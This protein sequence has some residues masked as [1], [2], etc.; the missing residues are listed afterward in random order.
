MNVFPNKIM[1]LDEKNFFNN[2]NNLYPS[3]QKPSSHHAYTKL[4]TNNI[5]KKLF[6][7]KN[8]TISS[9]R[10]KYK[11]KKFKSYLIL[12]SNT[13][14]NLS[15]KKDLFKESHIINK[16][17][18]NKASKI[19]ETKKSSIIRSR[20]FDNMN[21][22]N[23]NIEKIDNKLNKN[24]NKLKALIKVNIKKRKDN[25]LIS[26]N[27]TIGKDKNMKPYTKS[28]NEIIIFNNKTEENCFF[29]NHNSICNLIS[30]E[31]FNNNKMNKIIFI[32]NFWRKYLYLSK[33]FYIISKRLSIINQA[34]I[35]L[36]KFIY[37][38]YFKLLK[39]EIFNIRYYFH[40]W[41]NKMY[42]YKILQ[43]IICLR[44][45]KFKKF[46][47][48]EQKKKPNLS[49]RQTRSNFNRFKSFNNSKNEILNNAN[50][51]LKKN[52]LSYLENISINNKLNNL[53]Q[54]STLSSFSNINHI[55]KGCNK[56]SEKSYIKNKKNNVINK[57]N[58][59]ILK[60]LFKN[61]EINYN[62]INSITPSNKVLKYANKFYN[63]TI[64]FKTINDFN[65]QDKYNNNNNN[66][67]RKILNRN[68]LLNKTNLS[69]NYIYNEIKHTSPSSTNNRRN[70]K[71]HIILTNININNSINVIKDNR[72]VKN[73]FYKLKK[74]DTCPVSIF[75]KKSNKLIILKSKINRC[76]IH[77]KNITCKTKLIKYLI[78]EKNKI[79]IRQLFVRK[80]IRIILDFF[81][82]IILKIYFDK[83]NNKAIQTGL[84]LKLRAF[85]L[86]NNKL[87]KYLDLSHK[88]NINYIEIKGIDVINNININN[89]IN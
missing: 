18:D 7:E 75:N 21:I 45:N 15:K 73:R 53:I 6:D 31:N 10:N 74:F 28:E 43:K 32:Q 23:H 39:N 29:N 3:L 62:S 57:S 87:K 71:P 36:K 17:N 24:K 80:T 33:N 35:K 47:K 65:E 61:H 44:K 38:Y 67:F 69:N 82:I 40:F 4:N 84:L 22:K 12:D 54:N 59:S 49:S 88:E 19:L 46:H 72:T 64:N 8:K 2:F 41:H 42:L 13:S 1:K 56:S 89:F 26:K 14:K 11:I 25:N 34:L 60:H 85:I 52:N 70:K 83:Y 51:S 79:K 37:S 78:K 20:I 58:K 50:F 16:S 86:K 48:I 9:Q 77:W 30:Q 76:F 5:N 66:I 81:Q 63:K 68:I 27:K 55:Q